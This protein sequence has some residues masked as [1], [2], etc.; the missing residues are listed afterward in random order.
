MRIKTIIEI[1]KDSMVLS[2]VTKF[3]KDVIKITGLRGLRHHCIVSK[4]YK[5]P[6]E[7]TGLELDT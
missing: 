1:E 4:F 7:I 6:F 3:H 5:V 2:I